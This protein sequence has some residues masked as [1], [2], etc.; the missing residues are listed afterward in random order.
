[1]GTGVTG[2]SIIGMHMT[3]VADGKTNVVE[4]RSKSSS[5]RRPNRPCYF[6]MV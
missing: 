1:L 2:V 6:T 3:S 5:I 4:S